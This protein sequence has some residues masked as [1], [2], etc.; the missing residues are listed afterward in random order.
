M[1]PR[2][3]WPSS[4]ITGTAEYEHLAGVEGEALR[5][6]PTWQEWCTHQ[7]DVDAVEPAEASI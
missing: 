6:N 1:S 7:A 4:L 2:A 3:W 5:D